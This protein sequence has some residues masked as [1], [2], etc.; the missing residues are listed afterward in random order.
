MLKYAVEKEEN[1]ILEH[2]IKKIVT[3]FVREEEDESSANN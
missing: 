3:N 2:I 1:D